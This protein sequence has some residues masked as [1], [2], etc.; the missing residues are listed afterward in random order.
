MLWSRP[1]DEVDILANGI[2]SAPIPVSTDPLL[3]RHNLQEMPEP[4]IEYIPTVFQVIGER[5]RFVLGQYNA[6]IAG[7]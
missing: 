7:N 6:C 1:L 5:L 4:L 2:G 3:W